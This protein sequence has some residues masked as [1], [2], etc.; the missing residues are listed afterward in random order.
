MEDPETGMNALSDLD[1]VRIL[2]QLDATQLTKPPTR[3]EIY[4]K[5]VGGTDYKSMLKNSMSNGTTKSNLDKN[6]DD[7]VKQRRRNSL[8]KDI[9][10]EDT[11]GLA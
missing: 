9:I 10:Q 2:A 8:K 11:V 5:F 4:G 1:S 3:S 6:V 7:I